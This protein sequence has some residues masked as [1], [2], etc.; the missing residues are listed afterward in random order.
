[1]KK[2]M[3][4]YQEGDKNPFMSE[5]EYPVLYSK[6]QK[7]CEKTNCRECPINNCGARE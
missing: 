2:E 7:I 6:E 3:K 5:E 4:E 1:M